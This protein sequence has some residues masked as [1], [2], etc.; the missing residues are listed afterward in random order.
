MTGLEAMLF[1]R[2]L[3]Q[4][5]FDVHQ[6][7]YHSVSAELPQVLD[8]LQA[9]ILALGRPVHLV[10]HSLGGLIALSLIGARPDL[11]IGRAVLLGSPVNGSRA[12]RAF[13]QWPGA[14]MLFG[15]L[16]DVQLLSASP[17]PDRFAVEI[18]VIAGSQSLGLGRFLGNLPEPNDGTVAV[19]ETVL[20]GAA[21]S[22]VLPVSHTGMMVSQAVVAET[23]AFLDNGRFSDPET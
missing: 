5:G 17:R 13:S 20:A 18:G 3:G 21:D 10:G 11:P 19:D 16:A 1:R 4:H 15:Q 23:A 6:F 22:V 9:A 12:A 7:H 8:N 14:S 2:R